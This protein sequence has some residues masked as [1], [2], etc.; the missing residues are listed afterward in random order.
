MKTT[1]NNRIKTE[2]ENQGVRPSIQR[3][4]IMEYLHRHPNTH[5]TADEIFAILSPEI[6][7][8]SRATV[9][10]TLH[11]FSSHNLVNCLSLDGI[12]TRYD[13]RL[14]PHGHFK[15]E[16]CG[17]ISNFSVNYDTMRIEGLVGFETRHKN[18]VFTGICPECQNNHKREINNER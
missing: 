18:V 7:T 8:L 13:V 4:K 10:N 3:L 5:P 16:H 6:P 17:R 12:E 15:C 9:Y 2:L 14:E 11:I 1:D